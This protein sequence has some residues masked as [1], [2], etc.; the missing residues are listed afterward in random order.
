VAKIVRLT[1]RAWV[2]IGLREN[3]ADPLRVADRLDDRRFEL[4][5]IGV[6]VIPAA[7]WIGFTAPT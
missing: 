2:E 4:V 7:L 3:D 5:R 1:A 6:D